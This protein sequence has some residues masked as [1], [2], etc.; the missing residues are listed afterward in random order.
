MS[1][2][3]DAYVYVQDTMADWE[4][5]HSGL[6]IRRDNC[7]KR[8]LVDLTWIQSM[9]GTSERTC[10]GEGRAYFNRRWNGMRHIRCN[11]GF[12]RVGAPE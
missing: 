5:G 11:R 7:W 10:G 9:A 6:H 3:I 4:I 1:G 12:S 8:Y 2:S